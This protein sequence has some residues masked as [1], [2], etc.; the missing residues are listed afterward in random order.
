MHTAFALHAELSLDAAQEPGAS[1]YAEWPLD[2][3][4]WCTR[5]LACVSALD[6]PGY[7]FGG[8][9][10]ERV[11]N[12]ELNATDVVAVP[13]GPVAMRVSV[14]SLPLQK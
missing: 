4:L 1:T 3:D 8:T 14:V 12:W 10:L 2:C 5:P 13:P 7:P 6:T 9:V 11:T